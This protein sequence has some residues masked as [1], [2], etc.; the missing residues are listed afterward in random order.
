MKKVFFNIV[1]FSLFLLPLAAQNNLLISPNDLRVEKVEGGCNLFIR[2]KPGLES[3]ML[4]ET[5][6]DPLGKEDNYAYRSREWNSVNGDE[7]RILDGE[8][9]DAKEKQLY[10]LIDS[11]AQDDKE[12]G[13]AFLIF[14]PDELVFGYEWSRNGTVQVGKGTFINIRGFEKKYCD[15]TGAYYDNP[16]MFNLEKRTRPKPPPAEE[17]PE[18]EPELEPEPEVVVLTDDYNP[19]A[20]DKFKEFSD[21]VIYSKGPDSLMD[22]ISS[23]L[24]SINPKNM[25]DVV[26]AIDATGSM[27]DDLESL[28]KDLVPRLTQELVAFG[29]VRFGLLLYR[30]YGDNFWTKGLPV[31]YYDWTTSLDEFLGNL[32]KI[33][34]IGTEG[35]DVP[36]PVY[37]ALFASMEFYKW[38]DEAQRKIILIGDAEPHPTP[39]RSGKYSKELVEITAKDKNVSITAIITPDDKRRRG[40]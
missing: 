27:K 16:Y 22:D 19:L 4:T 39:R 32:N 15:Y 8:F 24:A 10:F 23:A 17:I 18:P 25:V 5:T 37:E 20:A 3:V 9:I 26:F 28:K 11:S 34:I 7:K 40:R 31:K 13:K 36:E 1:F 21:M 2:K 29:D 30:D 12:F 14:I 35:G 6:K 33:R 38:R